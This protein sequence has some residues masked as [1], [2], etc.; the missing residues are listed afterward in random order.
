MNCSHMKRLLLGLPITGSLNLCL[1]P[2]N[3]RIFEL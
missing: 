1:F 3:F 2:V